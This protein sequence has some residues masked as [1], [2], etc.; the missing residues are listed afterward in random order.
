MSHDDDELAH[1]NPPRWPL[2]Y[3][4]MYPREKWLWFAQLWR[5]ACMLRDRY[6]L[7]LRSVW[8]E[9][10]IQVETLAALAAWTDRFDSGAWDDPSAKIVLLTDLERV[11]G[12]LR[13]GVDP[14]HPERDRAAFVHYVTRELGARP[15]RSASRPLEAPVPG[16]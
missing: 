8:W 15:P 2:T 6:R 1:D 7:P 5:D 3:R 4:G 9:S 16:L 14:F 11:A 13:D 10:E 12:L